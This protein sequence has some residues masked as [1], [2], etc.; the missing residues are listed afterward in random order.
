MSSESIDV[1]IGGEDEVCERT[2]NY[3]KDLFSSKACAHEGF[4]QAFI[5]VKLMTFLYLIILA[6][7][8]RE[9][10]FIKAEPGKFAIES[11]IVALAV[12]VPFI[13]M[14]FYRQARISLASLAMWSLIMFVMF[15]VMNVLFELSGFYYAGSADA[16][17]K[18][19][20][21]D[22][23]TKF[24]EGV[25]KASLGTVLLLFV[26]PILIMTVAAFKTRDFT[27]PGV[28]SSGVV[29]WLLFLLEAVFM[30]VVNALPFILIAKNRN[31]YKASDTMPKV[32]LYF[33]K[34]VVLHIL[35]QLSGF[36]NS[37]FN[38]PRA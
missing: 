23:K 33:A 35:L 36:Y 7:L 2:G 30:A 37:F 12:V 25:T 5:F 26:V 20:K 15:F 11:A 24:M 34:L 28:T 31:M 6:A 10:A 18:P 17:A 3:V 32:A 9:V 22:R 29:N 14:Y 8:N 1:K 27:I 13:V 4:H 19:T 38:I 21:E 16:P